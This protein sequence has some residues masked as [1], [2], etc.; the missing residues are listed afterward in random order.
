MDPFLKYRSEPGRRAH[1]FWEVESRRRRPPAGPKTEM[2]GEIAPRANAEIY[3]TVAAEGS[4]HAFI[5][6]VNACIHLAHGKRHK[7][8]TT[9]LSRRS[10][11]EKAKLCRPTMSN[12]ST[13]PDNNA[14]EDASSS[15]PN[16]GESNGSNSAPET[17]PKKRGPTYYYAIRKCAGLDGPAIFLKESDASR[18]LA[19]DKAAI[20]RRFTDA[21]D[22]DAWIRGKKKVSRKRKAVDDGNAAKSK[23]LKDVIEK[24]DQL[25]EQKFEELKTFTETDGDGDPNLAMQKEYR[26]PQLQAWL[27][28]QRR[29]YNRY[30]NNEVNE[31]R[32][33]FDRKERF[34]KLLELGVRLKAKK[35]RAL[36]KNGRRGGETTRWTTPAF[37]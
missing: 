10:K 22:A 2:G 15:V 24:N 21:D 9:T 16:N 26:K 19:E 13:N 7:Q 18:F 27:S 36:G 25:W 33:Q 12:S 37:P 35:P 5:L 29:N 1:L 11:E 6:G 30:I 17:V 31:A 32:S 14:A 34:Y 4:T 8:L 20:H 3:C 28:G 23:V